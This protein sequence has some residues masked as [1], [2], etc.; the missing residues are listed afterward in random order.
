MRALPIVA[1]LLSS[2]AFA[3]AQKAPFFEA[4]PG[5]KMPLVRAHAN[6]D[7]AGTIARVEIEQRWATSGEGAIEATY[8]FSSSTEAAISDLEMTIG[9][10]VIRADLKPRSKAR[11]AY[12]EAK[13]EGKVATLLEMERPNVLSMRVAN[14]T[15]GQPVDVKIAYH[16]RIVPTD[17]IYE[18]VY[19]QAFLPRYQRGEEGWSENPVVKG[20]STSMDWGV[21]I[22]VVTPAKLFALGSPSHALNPQF[23]GA[24]RA[25]ATLSSTPDNLGY[26]RDLVLRYR[27][28]NDELEVGAMMYR[29]TRKA[30]RGKTREGFFSLVVE[31][32]S[33]LASDAHQAK[34]L[35]FIVDTSGSMSGFPL[36]TAKRL[37][38]ELTSSLRAEDRVNAIFFA[39]GNEVLFDKSA[40]ATTHNI[41]ILKSALDARGGGG[42]TRLD[43]ALDTAFA[44]D[45]RDDESRVYVVITDGGVAYEAS[46]FA[47]TRARLGGAN[48][49]VFGV[50]RTP[51]RY[52]T[53][54]LAK[55]GRARAY[56]VTHAGEIEAQVGAFAR[57]VRA[58]AL[59]NV[60]VRYE[61]FK[62]REVFPKAFPDVYPDQPLVVTGK[63]VGPS[64]GTIVVEGT[65][66][67][68]P[69]RKRIKIEDNRERKA[70]RPLRALWAREKLE[71]LRAFDTN[72][73]VNDRTEKAIVE[74]AMRYRLLTR[75]TS[76]V[77]IDSEVTAT[78]TAR[79]VVQPNVVSHGVALGAAMGSAGLGPRGTGAGGIGLGTVGTRGSG[80]G[81]GGYGVGGVDL[82]G[83][84]KG[85]VRMRMGKVEL[86]GNID[87]GTVNMAIRRYH[88][89]VRFVYEK[90]L[91]RD[92]HLY[93]KVVV[94]MV[95]NT[96]GRVAKVMSVKG[97]TITDAKML[98]EL[99]RV[100]KRMRF[101]VPRA[102]GPVI[103]TYPFVFSSR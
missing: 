38:S 23:A 54:G 74:H 57:R 27:L 9:D 77:A 14:I 18:L 44:M 39:G 31:P 48:L 12:D 88:R 35:V 19:P 82:G 99:M 98:S 51:N 20:S 60:R 42:G 26:D 50:G 64:S 36:Q 69:F 25:T 62:A 67:D 79:T 8:R 84:G 58:A 73:R 86:R 96:D 2:T 75:F 53:E 24:K 55:A 95:I 7:I 59:T 71:T 41:D 3:S 10:R 70:Y 30:A 37:M 76:F 66:P 1:L 102:D 40:P 49:F 100:L 17:G 89:Q 68:G 33:E 16:E 61:G 47:K 11:A 15:A 63:F 28:A 93:G 46:L 52:L 56:T 85:A 78:S 43:K 81:R 34:E 72:H 83:R 4:P 22:H 5:H 97:T 101:P 80:A 103:I 6:I 90:A 92:P 32:P 94:Q 21:D 45:T 87:K 91:Q 13:A 29:E 65:T